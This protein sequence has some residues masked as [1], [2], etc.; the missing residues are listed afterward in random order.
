MNESIDPLLPGG[1]SVKQVRRYP[2]PSDAFH[3]DMQD[4]RRCGYACDFLLTTSAYL[5]RAFLFRIDTRAPCIR[6]TTIAQLQAQGTI[7][8]KGK[9]Y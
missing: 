8:L 3:G 4:N 1:G 9:P 7:A 5:P 6:A 2:I